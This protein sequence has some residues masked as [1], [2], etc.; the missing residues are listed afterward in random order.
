MQLICTNSITLNRKQKEKWC[1][2]TFC[3]YPKYSVTKNKNIS[4]YLQTPRFCCDWNNNLFYLD[5][6]ISKIQKKFNYI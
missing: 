2:A 5:F 6:N 1:S 3:T 4:A